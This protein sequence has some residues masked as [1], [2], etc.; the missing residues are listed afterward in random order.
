MATNL[1]IQISVVYVGIRY[2]GC[3]AWQWRMELQVFAAFVSAS[4]L[5]KQGTLLPSSIGR[6]PK[7]GGYGEALFAVGARLT[8]TVG[9]G[10]RER[11]Q[12]VLGHSPS[13]AGY[14]RSERLETR[15]TD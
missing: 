9:S 4:N 5:L 15:V 2:S 13:N 3:V 12:S 8:R 11:V 7:R 1:E 10:F 14:N 6:S